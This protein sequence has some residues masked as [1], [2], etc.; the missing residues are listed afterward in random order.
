MGYFSLT[1]KT[2]FY[3]I[4]VE[5]RIVLLLVILSIKKVEFL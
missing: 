4:K 2:N 5:A 1:K 3:I